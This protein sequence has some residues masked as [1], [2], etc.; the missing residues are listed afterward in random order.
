MHGDR[1]QITGCF[2]GFTRKG[3]EEHSGVIQM[4]Y[5]LMWG[6]VTQI[7]IYLS[8]LIQ[9]HIELIYVHFTVCKLS[10]LKNLRNS[11]VY[12]FLPAITKKKISY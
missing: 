11:K 3:Q 1:N 4:F 12:I 5:I 2:R 8:K 9:R 7:Y 10:Q 6:Q